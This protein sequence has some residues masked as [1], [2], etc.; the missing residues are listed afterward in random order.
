[1]VS[2]DLRR[3]PSGFTCA[4]EEVMVKKRS[5][6]PEFHTLHPLAQRLWQL[7]ENRYNGNMAAFGRATQIPHA[8][9]A[10]WFNAQRSVPPTA[11]VL[12][13][14]AATGANPDWLL[15]GEGEMLVRPPEVPEQAI[16]PAQGKLRRIPVVSSVQAGK[17]GFWLDPFPAGSADDY[18]L[19]DCDDPNCYALRVE[20]DSMRPFLRPGDVLVIAPNQVPE[21]G[22]L[23][24]VRMFKSGEVMVKVWHERQ[25]GGV[26]VLKSYNAAYDDLVV[27]RAELAF[28][29]R[30][31]AVKMQ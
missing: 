29:H 14:A 25:S 16:Y 8:T 26:I 23:A 4:E 6:I 2:V 5:D 10:S 24:V 3:R 21:N 11:T 7:I 13:I 28:T 27:N 30:V 31:V 22:R 18:T 12:G 20:G 9:I 17:N 19:A 1:L 15:S